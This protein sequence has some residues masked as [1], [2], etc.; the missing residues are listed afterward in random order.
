MKLVVSKEAAADLARLR[1]FL[2]DK[3][4]RAAANAAARLDAAIRSLQIFPGRGRPSGIPGV[5][6]LVVPF[7]GSAY[8][9]RYA[10]N[11]EQEMVVV[12]RVWH[13]REE[14]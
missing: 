3:E 9:L 6:E 11:A 13:G 2:E 10:H 5:R 14:R 7:G 1:G 4:P 8:L 12:I